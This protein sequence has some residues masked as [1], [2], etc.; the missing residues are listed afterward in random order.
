VTDAG[1]TISINSNA[2]L[3]LGGILELRHAVRCDL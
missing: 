1:A 2:S 3:T